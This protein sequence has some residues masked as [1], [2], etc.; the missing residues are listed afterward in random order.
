MSTAKT[1]PPVALVTGAGKR[2]GRAI[3]LGLAADGWS[4]ALHFHHSRAETELLVAEIAARGGSAVAL[5]C[6]LSQP[7]QVSG[8]LAE[9]ERGLGP[10]TCLVNNAALFE[11][12]D[13]ARLEVEA[14]HRHLDVNLLAP[15]LL[16]KAFAARLPEGRTGCI[17]NLLDQK[18]FNLNPDFL[19]YTIA[20]IALEGATR[21]LAMALAPRIRVCGVAPGITLISGKQ[22]EQGFARAHARAPLGQSST[23]DD[24]AGAVRFVVNA[25]A[26]TGTTLVV[27]G[28]QHLWP[29]RRDVQ[30]E[31][32]TRP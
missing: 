11:Y 5:E 7:A 10:P 17:V 20:K 27:D 18:V 15:V 26:F 25:K 31:T 21:V 13:L 3:S 4:V 30:F 14:W 32:D 1:K 22:T 2:I 9:C 12:D 8:L 29:T 6:D 23:M 24:I 16:A 28:G 19:S